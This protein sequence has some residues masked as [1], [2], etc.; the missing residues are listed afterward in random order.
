M[1]TR[2]YETYTGEETRLRML[3]EGLK[4]LTKASLDAEYL[5]RRVGEDREKSPPD[6]IRHQHLEVANRIRDNL[7]RLGVHS[8]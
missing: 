2:D 1:T 3:M 7:K 8:T 6:V 4:E 5:M